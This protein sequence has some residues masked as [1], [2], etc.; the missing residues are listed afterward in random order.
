VRHWLTF[1]S[2]VT[3]LD[4]DGAQE[5]YWADAFPHNPR[6]P[7]DVVD[8]SGR[9]LIAAQAS[10]SKVTTKLKTRFRPGFSAGMRARDGFTGQIF[11]IEAVI[12]DPNS[13]RRWVHMLCTSGVNAG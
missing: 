6:M 10:H 13:R 7:C 3:E 1:E 4:S 2:Q 5:T 12:L 9:E 11:N 8:M